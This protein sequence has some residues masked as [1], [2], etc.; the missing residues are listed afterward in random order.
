MARKRP[1]DKIG[2][3]E[4]IT[5]GKRDDVDPKSIKNPLME[6]LL[7]KQKKV[8]SDVARSLQKQSLN[9]VT[10][11]EEPQEMIQVGHVSMRGKTKTV[12]NVLFQ[13]DANGIAEIPKLA[14]TERAVL[15][16]QPGYYDPEKVEKK[17]KVHERFIPPE[18]VKHPSIEDKK[19]TKLGRPKISLGRKKKFKV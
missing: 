5:G 11:V 7:K 12:N 14:W 17:E 9:T 16:K 10:V 1:E 13:F 18:P 2:G 6:G 3:I 8:G 15:L 4:V 19:K